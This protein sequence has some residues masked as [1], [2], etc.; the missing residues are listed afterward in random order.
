MFWNTAV[1]LFQLDEG[2]NAE[3]FDS[4][5]PSIKLEISIY[6]FFNTKTGIMS[7]I[8]FIEMSEPTVKGSKANK[9]VKRMSNEQ[10]YCYLCKGVKVPKLTRDELVFMN[11]DMLTGTDAYIGIGKIQNAVA[12]LLRINLVK[13]GVHPEDAEEFVEELEELGDTAKALEHL[14]T[15]FEA[16]RSRYDAMDK[17]VA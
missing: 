13:V 15:I 5:V 1:P 12:E 14:Y 9:L 11:Y 16:V 7:K 10:I 2:L 17:K 6:I 3:Q 4:K 8:N